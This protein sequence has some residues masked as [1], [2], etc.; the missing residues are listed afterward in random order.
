MGIDG[1][2]RLKEGSM[3]T[4]GCNSNTDP[5]ALDTPFANQSGPCE[6]G[7]GMHHAMRS[8]S[9][10]AI[11]RKA[12]IASGHPRIGAG[13]NYRSITNQSETYEGGR[14][15]LPG[16]S[17]AETRKCSVAQKRPGSAGAPGSNDTSSSPPPRGGGRTARAPADVHALI[18]TPF[19]P[20]YVTKDMLGEATNLKLILTAGVGSTIVAHLGEAA[21]QGITVA[22]I[23]GSARRGPSV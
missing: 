23:T 8:C 15:P 21:E 3:A 22:E 9:V 16:G 13:A 5:L 19:W 11:R 12:G 14:R 2:N 18:T 4:A 7:T 6:S 20:V 1:A 17:A 10:N